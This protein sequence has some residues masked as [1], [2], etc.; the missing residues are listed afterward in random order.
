MMIR[1][2]H[3]GKCRKV[4]QPLNTID[5]LK[6]KISELFGSSAAKLDI[7]YKDCDG[8]LVSVV[9]T[10]DLANCIDEAQEFKMTC[11]TLLLKEDRATS[12]SVSSKKSSQSSSESEDGDLSSDEEK[13]FAIIGK[14]AVS[15]SPE[16]RKATMKLIEE[17]QKAEVELIKKKLIEE[18]QKALCELDEHTKDKIER[19]HKI[20]GERKN[21]SCEKGEDMK[22]QQKIMANLKVINQVCKADKI[23]NPIFTA[24]ALFKDLKEEFPQLDCNPALVNLIMLDA[25]ETLR[26]SLKVSC[27][28][29]ISQNPEL[30]KVSEDKKAKFGAEKCKVRGEKRGRERKN[31]DESD[32]ER[33]ARRAARI[34]MSSEQKELR[35]IEKE[36]RRLEKAAEKAERHAIKAEQKHSKTAHSQDDKEFKSKV[37]ALRETFPTI[38]KPQLKAIVAQNAT[39]S[40]QELIPLIKSSKIGK[41]N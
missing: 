35:Q 40:V 34:K 9:D 6:A 18:H 28:R 11:V 26:N 39:L 24:H 7:S 21:H 8:E 4:T 36:A 41:S 14:T 19:I 38:K 33:Q 37:N 30:A 2:K 10:E 17:Q 29:I 31:K 23:E 1:I 16:E 27:Q 22:K 20:K 5:E 12:R 32:P 25:R 15:A 13:G 3:E